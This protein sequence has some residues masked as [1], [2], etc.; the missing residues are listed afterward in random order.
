MSVYQVAATLPYAVVPL[1]G[2]V[3]LPLTGNNYA[4]LFCILAACAAVAGA[5]V[6]FVRSIR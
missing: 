2:A 6:L 5:A 3:L 1:I 4:L